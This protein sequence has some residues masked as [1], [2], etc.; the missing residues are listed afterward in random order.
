ME[1][2]ATQ[3]RRFLVAGD[4]ESGLDGEIAASE[5]ARDVAGDGE[6]G[7]DPAEER[8]PHR[9]RQARLHPPWHHRIQAQHN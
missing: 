6:A 7:G 5:C 3:S 1:E 2:R 8:H 9:L 4:V